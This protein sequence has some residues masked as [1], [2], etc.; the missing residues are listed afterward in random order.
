MLRECIWRRTTAKQAC[1]SCSV[2]KAQ[3]PASAAQRAC[4]QR[5]GRA[6]GATR[7]AIGPSELPE[8]LSCRRNT[9]PTIA[10]AAAVTAPAAL[11]ARPSPPCPHRLP[12]L[13]GP[14]A[15]RLPSLTGSSAHPTPGGA[16][17]CGHRR[18]RRVCLHRHGFG[19][20]MRQGSSAR[21]AI[22]PLFSQALLVGGRNNHTQR[23]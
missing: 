21:A 3:A 22:F 1:L 15:H 18:H 20:R 12:S 6:G 7:H 4:Q 10:A 23:D 13:T 14:S 17:R 19:E 9:V 2:C 5:C 16:V 11:C 8:L